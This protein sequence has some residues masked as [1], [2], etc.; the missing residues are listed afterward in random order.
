MKLCFSCGLTSLQNE[1]ITQRQTIRPYTIPIAHSP[2]FPVR[3][4][5]KAA[6]GYNRC[7]FKRNKVITLMMICVCYEHLGCLINN[8]E[9]G[10]KYPHT[11]YHGNINLTWMPYLLYPI[12]SQWSDD[13]FAP[14]LYSNLVMLADDLTPPPI[15][16]TGWN[17]ASPFTFSRF[18]MKNSL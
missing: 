8:I 2:V 14:F 15:I 1:Y 3:C 7:Q 10:L 12:H 9:E 5:Y 16:S 17:S 6:L 4:I 11:M 18:S 13:P